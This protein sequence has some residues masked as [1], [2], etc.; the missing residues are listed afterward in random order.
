[1]IIGDDQL[2]PA[3]ANTCSATSPA[4]VCP[5]CGRP[6]CFAKT[7]M[8]KVSASLACGCARIDLSF[9]DLSHGQATIWHIEVALFAMWGE[10]G[11]AAAAD[12][13]APDVEEF[14]RWRYSPGG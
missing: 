14:H 7:D 13:L 11:A 6:M 12:L 2:L 3:P 5:R 8:F 4:N 10:R 1:M 9:M